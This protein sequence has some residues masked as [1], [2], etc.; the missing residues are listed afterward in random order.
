MP[1]FNGKIYHEMSIV[2]VVMPLVAI[3]K[4]QVST[5]DAC[6]A[7]SNCFL[8]YKKDCS[9]RVVDHIMYLLAYRFVYNHSKA[10]LSQ[11]PAVTTECRI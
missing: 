5:L 10:M 11:L 6:L 1:F 2:V 7:Y 9:I 3:M 4:D 8:K